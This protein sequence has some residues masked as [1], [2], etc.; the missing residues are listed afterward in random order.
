MTN[1]AIADRIDP[2]A[3]GGVVVVDN[4]VDDLAVAAYGLHHN[5]HHRR[6]DVPKW[7]Q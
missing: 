5:C 2:A 1:F 7:Q 3:A 4:L 6:L